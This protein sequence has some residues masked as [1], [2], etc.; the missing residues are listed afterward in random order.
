ML[1]SD[2]FHIH[3]TINYCKHNFIT[4]NLI[5]AQF[6]RAPS[7]GDKDVW[8][9]VLFSV[10]LDGRQSIICEA[11]MAFNRLY[12]S[13]QETGGDKSL[14]CDQMLL[15]WGV[16][17]YILLCLAVLAKTFMTSP[18]MWL[19]RFRRMWLNQPYQGYCGKCRSADWYKH[20]FW[21]WGFCKENNKYIC[22]FIMVILL[23]LTGTPYILKCPHS[24]ITRSFLHPSC[25]R[26]CLSLFA[27]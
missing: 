22:I 8:R 18:I 27:A 21:S 9:C 19:L 17:Q 13:L 1:L 2:I 3:T 25:E 24:V 11:G 16:A 20:P 12:F 14:L 5:V 7:G 26:K 6:G 15:T 4:W 10:H 23:R